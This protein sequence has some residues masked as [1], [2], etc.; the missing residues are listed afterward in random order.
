MAAGG[1]RPWGLGLL[2]G[3]RRLRGWCCRGDLLG[4]GDGGGGGCSCHG[5]STGALEG[6][7]GAELPP[8]DPQDGHHL[9]H[10]DLRV[11]LGD[12]GPGKMKR[13]VRKKS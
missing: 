8:L 5:C 9:R 13:K 11:L 4:D 6:V 2:P 3:W 10:G 12:H 1:G 7:V